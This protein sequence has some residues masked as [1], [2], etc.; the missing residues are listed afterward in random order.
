MDKELDEKLCKDF[1][2]IFR[3]RYADM[4]TTCMCWG[5]PNSGWEPLIRTFCT[6]A[7]S[8]IN[9]SRKSRA[10]YLRHKRIY[11]RV[12]KENRVREY[13]EQYYKDYYDNSSLVQKMVADPESIYQT[14]DKQEPVACPQVVAMQVKEKFGTIRFYYSGGDDYI[15]GLESFMDYMSGQTCESCG[16]PGKLRGGGWILCECDDCAR[17]KPTLKEERE[18]TPL[19]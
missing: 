17:G 11:K 12:V 10:R 16:K 2:K 8:H 1:P 5:F 9:H 13:A 6:L 4:R 15:S 3:D 19:L 7:Q 18:E 14:W